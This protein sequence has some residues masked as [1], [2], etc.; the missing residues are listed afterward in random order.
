MKKLS[1]DKQDFLYGGLHILGVGSKNDRKK[2]EILLFS[3]VP[4]KKK[5]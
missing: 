3:L 5:G 4:Q 1:E 2:D